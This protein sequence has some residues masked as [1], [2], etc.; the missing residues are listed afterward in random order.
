MYIYIT[1][2]R[3]INPDEN[4]TVRISAMLGN[5]SSSGT[6]KN[7]SLTTVLELLTVL[8]L[9]TVLELLT[10]LGLLTVLELLLTNSDGLL[11][12]LGIVTMALAIL[13]V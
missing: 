9:S 4:I 1:S 3:N 11:A 8:A 13:D 5:I 7:V 6:I 2:V 10:V 12:M